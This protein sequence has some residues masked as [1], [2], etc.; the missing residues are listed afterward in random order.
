MENEGF[1]NITSD[2]LAIKHISEIEA[3]PNEI[4]K[5]VSHLYDKDHTHETVINN[6]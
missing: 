3:L 1:I 6:L 5:A 2:L 4:E